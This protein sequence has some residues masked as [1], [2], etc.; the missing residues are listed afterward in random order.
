[1]SSAF[2]QHKYINLVL[3]LL[4]SKS[5]SSKILQLREGER[6]VYFTPKN[7]IIH[8]LTD[9]FSLCSR[10]KSQSLKFTITSAFMSNI[11]PNLEQDYTSSAKIKGSEV[12]GGLKKKSAHS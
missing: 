2:Q 3:S 1:M 9:I 7:K 5:P 11:S 8:K 10:P 12:Q 4:S 6:E